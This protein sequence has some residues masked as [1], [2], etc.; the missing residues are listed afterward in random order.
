MISRACIPLL[1]GAMLAER[2]V[3]SHHLRNQKQFEAAHREATSAAEWGPRIEPCTQWSRVSEKPLAAGLSPRP[4]REL[5]DAMRR[6][7]CCQQWSVCEVTPA[8][9]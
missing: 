8:K 9:L 5:D 4:A 2:F 7:D 6:F 1:L 3:V